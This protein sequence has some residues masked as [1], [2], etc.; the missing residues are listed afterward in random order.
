M[1]NISSAINMLKKNVGRLMKPKN[2]F[3]KGFAKGYEK[4]IKDVEWLK[5]KIDDTEEKDIERYFEVDKRTLKIKRNAER[6]SNR[7]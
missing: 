7:S 6:Y 3:M 2:S 5:N 4:A 1:D